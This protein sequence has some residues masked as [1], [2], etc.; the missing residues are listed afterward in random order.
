MTVTARGMGSETE[1]NGRGETD[2][3]GEKEDERE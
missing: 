1:V 3:W 2:R